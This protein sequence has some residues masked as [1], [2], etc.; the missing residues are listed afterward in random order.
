MNTCPTIGSVGVFFGNETAQ[1]NLTQFT[2][3]TQTLLAN[4]IDTVYVKVFSGANGGVSGGPDEWYGPIGGFSAVKSAI[5]AAGI[6]NVIPWGYM[7]GNAAGS[8]LADEIALV[9]KYMNLYG[10]FVADIEDEWSG[11]VDWATTLNAALA[12]NAN[13]LYVSCLADPVEHNMVGVWAALAPSVNVWM[14]QVYTDN[15][16]AMYPPEW[17]AYSCLQ[18]TYSFAQDMGPN[19]VLSNI[20][21]SLPV[22]LWEYAYIITV[23][24]QLQALVQKVNAPVSIPISNVGEIA[25]FCDADQFQPAKTQDACGFF[26]VWA[27]LAASKVGS[28]CGLSASQV[29]NGALSDYALYDGDNSISNQMGMSLSQLYQLLSQR[30]LHWQ[31]VNI[32]DPDL[33]NLIRAWVRAGYPLILA[34][35]EA[36]MFDIGLG[37]VV[38]YYWN[39]QSFNHIISITGVKSDG[40]VLVRDPANVTDLNNP[41]S[42]RPGPRNYD[43]TKFQPISLTAVVLPWMPRPPAGFDPRKDTL[44][45]VPTGWSDNGSILTAPNN[46]TVHGM[47]RSTVLASTWAGNNW[48][49]TEEYPIT[50][51]EDGVGPALQPGSVAQDFLYSSLY[52]SQADM[53]VGNRKIGQDYG[54]QKQQAATNAAAVATLTAQ[55]TS[56][57]KNVAGLT[58][59]VSALQAQVA[60]LQAGGVSA[61]VQQAVDAALA[62]AASISTA[63]TPY[64]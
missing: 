13:Y 49:V 42:L 26:A 19:S 56:L 47:I 9:E 14:P 29:I 64:K 45:M 46:L 62:A 1:W 4:G 36:G 59:Q 27:M 43:V 34:G 55:V 20:T 40:S 39:Y 6:N 7:Y 28:A 24:P 21:P 17:S 18:P 23:L 63:L 22:T 3:A 53:H 12:S 38:P 5:Q 44:S 60:Q 10:A 51:V 41:N 8:V 31:A 58:S 32:G 25:D 15:L 30:G 11:H 57:T 37:D 16:Q 2:S 33:D 61:A 50:T 54:Y 35:G 48:P 52:F